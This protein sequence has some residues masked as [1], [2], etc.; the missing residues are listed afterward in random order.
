MSR[1]VIPAGFG[2]N[3]EQIIFDT[4]DISTKRY[5][6]LYYVNIRR[7]PLGSPIFNDDG[8]PVVY[9]FRHSAY[10]SDKGEIRKPLEKFEKYQKKGDT[11]LAKL[12][13]YEP[14]REIQQLGMKISSI[15]MLKVMKGRRYS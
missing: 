14:Y 15:H 12:E 7:V 2:K 6:Q 5:P 8:T 11:P 4:T 9:K 3:R 13:D 10:V 1:T